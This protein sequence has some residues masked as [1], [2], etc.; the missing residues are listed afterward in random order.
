LHK[1]VQRSEKHTDHL[2]VVSVAFPK[3]I[4]QGTSLRIILFVE[5]ME[6][7]SNAVINLNCL[8]FKPRLAK[9]ASK[10]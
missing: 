5:F 6:T 4:T 2:H 3:S 1:A 10:S 9:I 8:F 7:S